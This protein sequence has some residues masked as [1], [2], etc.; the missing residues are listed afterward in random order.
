MKAAIKSAWFVIH[1]PLVTH[2]ALEVLPLGQFH[3]RDLLKNAIN[4]RVCYRQIIY[5]F[6]LTAVWSAD[7]RPCLDHCS[8]SFY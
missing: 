2:V 5:C 4:G 3:L 8:S 7:N 1:S 6:D